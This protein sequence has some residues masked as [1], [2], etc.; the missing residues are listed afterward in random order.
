MTCTKCSKEKTPEQMKPK[1]KW[2][3]ECYRAYM[4]KWK[5]TPSGKASIKK[6]RSSEKAKEYYSQ[7]YRDW[8]AKNGRKRNTNYRVVINK[9]NKENP[10]KKKAHEIL[11]KVV[12]DGKITKPLLCEECGREARLSGHHTDYAKPLEV[13]FLCS[14]CHKKRH[15]K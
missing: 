4:R 1:S 14:S 13:I 10:E 11:L 15:S 9:W 12:M 2:C 5:K 8:Y 6:D 7:W 3:R